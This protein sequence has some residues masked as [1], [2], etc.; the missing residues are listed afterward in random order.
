MLDHWW[1]TG[2]GWPVCA[3]CVG[4]GMLPVKPGSPS[5]PVPGWDVRVLDVSGRQA[6][7]GDIGA[8]VRKLPLPPGTL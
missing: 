2:T 7:P 1:Q 4:L 8:L 6:M 5:R 3:N